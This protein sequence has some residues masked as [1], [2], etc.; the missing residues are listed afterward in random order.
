[1]W[2]RS[3]RLGRCR[4]GLTLVELLVVIVII[5]TLV[6]LL[7]PAVQLVREGARRSWCASRM[8][9]VVLGVGQ[10]E[11][12]YRMFPMS[13]S[14][15]GSFLV[16]VL[17]FVEQSALATEVD[18]F[19][20]DGGLLHEFAISNPMYNCASDGTPP[21]VGTDVLIA[22]SNYC[23]NSGSW[24]VA[25]REFDG[26]FLP[27]IDVGFGAGPVRLQDV[28]D[29]L[30][31]TDCVSEWLRADGTF[32][33]MRATWNTPTSYLNASID[34]ANACRSIPND[35]KSVGWR[36]D[37]FQKGTP[38]V[39]GNPLVTLFNHVCTPNSPSCFN[40]N[41]VPTGAGS[42][43][44]MHSGIVNVAF[45]DGHIKAVS[46]EIDASVWFAYGSRNGADL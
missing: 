23:G 5:V 19:F 13:P 39:D 7:L 41:G 24:T 25:K 11:A 34:F 15:D 22:G 36:G 12:T 9:Q 21:A 27:N 38:W 1:M 31:H 35:A 28:V 16:S 14:Y 45:T 17:P 32:S 18:E 29:G 2:K 6:A 42:V 20:S 46:N 43:S 40:K 30:S 3:R 37:P 26:I 4:K 33:R 10:Y 8:R 44:S